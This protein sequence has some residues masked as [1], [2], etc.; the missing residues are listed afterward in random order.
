MQAIGL[1]SLVD[2]NARWFSVIVIRLQVF[3]AEVLRI[4]KEKQICRHASEKTVYTIVWS[5]KYL[6]VSGEAAPALEFFL[7]SKSLSQ[8]RLV[9]YCM[10]C[11][12]TC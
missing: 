11:R 7:S 5:H 12:L 4:E 6:Q 8:T 10:S 9:D 2:A 3:K 1:K